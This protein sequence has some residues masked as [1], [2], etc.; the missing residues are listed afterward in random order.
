M[1]FL[2]L[3]VCAIFSLMVTACERNT[4][5]N[6]SPKQVSTGN[7]T[8]VKKDLWRNTG[9][10][11][12]SVNM[13]L[14]KVGE[15]S[16]YAEGTPGSATEHEG[17]ISNAGV[18]ITD[19]GVVVFDALGTPSL[20]YLLLSRIRELTDKPILRV[21]TSHYH[22]D[23]IYGLQ[24]FK[25]FACVYNQK[26][27]E[28]CMPPQIWAPRGAEV[29]L[30]SE[31]A[32]NRLNERKESL[33]PW[34]DDN[35]RIIEPDVYISDKQQFTLGGINFSTTPLGSTHSQGD[36]ML[37]V[38][39]DKVLY[40]GDLIFQGR[41]PFVEGD[42]TVW[43]RQLSNLDTSHIQVI[44]PGHGKAYAD[45]ARAVSF[46]L[47]YLQYVTDKMQAAVDELTPFD[48]VYNSTDW[49]HYKDMPAFI[50]NRPNAYH[51]YLDL[52]QKSLQQN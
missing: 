45:P 38:D 11:P 18:V 32:K 21:V 8:S 47:G 9:Y 35:T 36:L 3:M 46:T 51:I 28:K 52:E 4:E 10:E 27:V 48:E 40:S 49:S 30:H 19:E 15:H 26:P 39:N 34:V 14:I 41:L 29:Y 24:V 7:H 20:G 13:E 5:D 50:A 2:R 23:H 44:V 42:T 17:F 16:Y 25:D 43:I 31:A 12:T 33:F 6:L 1:I 22:A 37:Q